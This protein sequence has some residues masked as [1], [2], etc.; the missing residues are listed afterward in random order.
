MIRASTVFILFFLANCFTNDT[1]AQFTN[2]VVSIIDP[3]ETIID[4]GSRGGTTFL[5]PVYTQIQQN[6]NG[7][8]YI[9]NS[10]SI[11]AGNGNGW[12]EFYTEDTEIIKDIALDHQEKLIVLLDNDLGFF[13]PT[14]EGHRYV[15]LLKTTPDDTFLSLTTFGEQI[16]VVGESAIYEFKYENLI[17]IEINGNSNYLVANEKTVLRVD[18]LKGVYELNG[19]PVVEV[20]PPFEISGTYIL[21]ENLI[22][23]E[24]QQGVFFWNS[25]TRKLNQLNEEIT[26]V[27]SIETV[28]QD[29]IAIGTEH[30][31]CFIIA[32]TGEILKQFSIEDDL[33]SNNISEIL[34]DKEGGIWL[35]SDQ[36][37]A[38]I[39][40]L[41]PALQLFDGSKHGIIISIQGFQDRIY[42]G[43]TKGLFV[44]SAHAADFS[45]ISGTNGYIFDLLALENQLLIAASGGVYSM[46]RSQKITQIGTENTRALVLGREE[47]K[48][49]AGQKKGIG[50]FSIAGSV[51]YDGQ[52]AG[53]EDDI[54]YLVIEEAKNILVAASVSPI[55]Y[56]IQ[57]PEGSDKIEVLDSA[58]GIKDN[59][60]VFTDEDQVKY[61]YEHGM[62]V[63]DAVKQLFVYDST[64]GPNFINNYQPY[65]FFKD[66]EDN[67]WISTNGLVE[68]YYKTPKGYVQDSTLLTELPSS[69]YRAL[70]VDIDG[71]SLM[72]G[73]DGLF[74]IDPALKKTPPKGFT[75]VISDIELNNEPSRS[76]RGISGAHIDGELSHNINDFV[77]RFA[78]PTFNV[79]ANE[80]YSYILEGY[81][82]KW[83]EWTG[84]AYKEYTNLSA[85]DYTF[86]VKAKS[87][88]GESSIA[89]ARFTI[90][91]AWYAT[92]WAWAAYL[93][94]FIGVGYT[95]FAFQRRRMMVK[96][97]TKLKAKQGEVD[98]QKKIAEKLLQID[99]LKDDFLA[100]TS[101]ELRTPL[102]GIIGISES[103]IDSDV[104]PNSEE[105]R[106]NLSLVVASGKR[107]SSLVDG[108][109]DYSKLKTK[110]LDLLMKPVDL[111]SIADVVVAMS[112]P[113]TKGHPVVI[114]NQIAR[115]VP[116]IWADENRMTQILYNLVG[117]AIKFTEDG[118]ISIQAKETDSEIEACVSDTGIGIDADRLE[119]IFDSFE[120][121]DENINRDYIGTGLGLTITKKLVELHK[122]DIWVTS[123]PGKGSSFYFTVPISPEQ[124][125]PI[126][127][128]PEQVKDHPNELQAQ[129]HKGKYNILIVDDEPIN[130]Q[131]LSN[132]LNTK[133]FGV[134]LASSGKQ[135]LE[136]LEAN[137][138]DMVL[139]D[140]MMPKMS[141]YEV[142]EHIRSK[143]LMSELPVIF[144][145]AKNQIKDLVEGFSYGANDYVTKPIS[146][147]EF[148][149]R[150]NTHL[151]LHKLNESY[152]RFVPHEFLKLLKRES[153]LDVEL[154]QQVEKQVTLLFSDIRS[155]TTI[156]ER[157]TPKENFE[158]LNSYLK[159]VGPAIRENGGFI[160]QYYGDG[161][162]ALFP[163]KPEDALK[164]ALKMVLLVREFNQETSKQGRERIRVGVGLHTGMSMLGI[165]GDEIRMDA[166]VVSDSVNI[167]SRME[168][169]TKFYSASIIMSESTLDLIDKKDVYDTRFLGKVVVKGK[170]KTTNV[171]EVFQADEEDVRLQKLATKADFE[172]GLETYFAKNFTAAA[173]LFNS[174]IERNP[175]DTAASHYLKNSADYMVTGVPDEWEGV[176][177][178]NFK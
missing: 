143:Y 109:L 55:V 81:D 135:A 152:A 122:G 77:F 126:T 129:T 66:R 63:Y 106:E 87:L 50:I 139:L 58:K 90:L 132:I 125:K 86:S 78:A 37:I 114:E 105:L 138:P 168:G 23:A 130:Q 35:T 136:L 101:H 43:T 140:I 164:T 133:G 19:A 88:F 93:I 134:T 116:L 17:P 131:V 128:Q 161:I 46:D 33:P 155:Y 10:A 151:N 107:L 68:K 39:E 54:R 2:S 94:A 56:H 76:F 41:Y 92:I 7:I 26:D 91:P 59:V 162:L 49:Y 45:E 9:Q 176:E 42:I 60:I 177:S 156:S 11:V 163:S 64:Y 47:K 141:G 169:L 171:I 44:G 83:S 73:N 167:A 61:G 67:A 102:N 157:M 72:G 3:E 165:L 31:G 21:G 65:R 160:S 14:R 150:V 69:T 119:S 146:K 16:F 149:A 124:V 127:H 99:R 166:T 30:N 95:M 48:I 112:T 29:Y 27:N 97:R 84:E 144:I 13:E 36:G 85:G 52:M 32:R 34:E 57:L 154:G 103:L 137:T 70:F 38:R 22:L 12:I 24:K 98:R 1:F 142:C 120:S 118:I 111:S 147:D 80:Q 173:G 51:R 25:S 20:D 174:V 4:N 115:D 89:S 113:L 82:T 18:P 104:P 75:A 79:N 53:V 158:F 121:E 123:A 159:K 175:D 153:I 8:V 96:L 71:T 5:T 117:N 170:S 15:S 74:R 28:G 108:I 40:Y 110:N 145:T 178:L 172:E 148:L 6:S 62:L 100:N